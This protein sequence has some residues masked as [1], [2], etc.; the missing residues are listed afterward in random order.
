MQHDAGR[1]FSTRAI[2]AAGRSP[3]LDQEPTAVPIYQTATFR[4]ADSS[5]LA[6]ILTDRRQGYAYSRIANPTS[7]ALADAVAEIEG[8]AEGFAFGT[9]MG[10][11]FA[12]LASQMS[13]GDEVV[14][15]NALYGSTRSLLDRELRRFGVATRYVD[16]TDLAGVEAA[17]TPATRILYVETISNPTIVVA[18]LAPLAAIAHRNAAALVVDNTFASPY[19]CRPAEL[20]ADLVVE[21]ATKW[22]AGHSDVMAGIVSG[23]PD[24]MAAV[25]ALQV[26]TGGVVAPFS[27]FLVLRGL[28]TL[29]V[30]MDRHS[31]TALAL[32]EYLERQD[33]VVRRVYYPGLATHPQAEVARRQLRT[34]GGML[35][36]DLGS[37]AAGTAFLDALEIGERT[38]SLGSVHTIAVHPPSTTHRQL[39]EAGLE[40]A[41]IAPGLVRMSVGLEDADD[42]LGD[43]ARALDVVRAAV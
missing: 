29:A 4:T 10:A 36:F 7:A 31:S 39:D 35:A 12:A 13:A 27:A 24:R 22:I 30:R 41:G 15:S 25:R 6:D 16:A 21:S 19:L 23:P 40:R 9:G 37:R 18:D 32:A 28:T 33:D 26:N 11:I 43:L 8:S 3:R 42:L 1:G 17:F 14:A 34:G 5:E 20:G 2:R 38:A